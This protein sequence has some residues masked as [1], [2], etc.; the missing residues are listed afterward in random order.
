MSKDG[1]ESTGNGES[2]TVDYPKEWQGL[3]FTAGQRIKIKRSW[4]KQLTFR[5]RLYPILGQPLKLTRTE[6]FNQKPLIQ[7]ILRIR[8]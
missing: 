8:H 7:K 4:W 3:T 6:R 2:F 1:W 5:G